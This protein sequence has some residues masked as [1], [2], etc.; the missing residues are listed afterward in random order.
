MKK[1]Y[2]LCIALSMLFLFHNVQAQAPDC[3]TNISPANLSTNINPYPFITFKWNA[4]SGASSYDIYVNTKVPPKQLVGT[5][6]VDSFNFNNA[7]YNT[8]Y[9][10]YVVPKNA[11]G[12]AIGCVSSAT[13]FT[14]SPPPPPPA[15]DNCGGAANISYIPLNGTTLGATQSQPANACGG[16]TGTAN[17]DVWYQFTPLTSGPITV[18]AEGSSSFDGVLEAFSGACGSLTSLSCSDTS[19]AGGREQITLNVEA[20]VNYKFR[21]YNFYAELSSRGTFSISIIPTPLPVTLL[22]FKG[23]RRANKNVLSWSTATELNNEGFELQYSADGTN[24]GKVAFVNSKAVNGNSSTILSYEFADAGQ[25][26][27]N[28][29][30]RLKQVDKKGQSNFSNIIFLKGEKVN[31]IT[32]GKI[33]PNP[34]KNKLNVA[35]AAPES[36]KIHLIVTDVAGKTVKQQSFAIING[37]NKLTVDV[38]GLPGGNYFIKAISR[39]GSQTDASKFVKE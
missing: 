1:I 27:G 3:T 17:D 30:Y 29:Y 6:S 2:T 5:V 25:L 10:W 28:A 36:S 18:N 32:L 21:I 33:Y 35:I 14:T 34:A 7:S 37:D 8:A 19:Q 15:N 23:E 4:V 39:D 22:N 20:G 26:S 9:Y 31:T 16:Y 38:A 24:F 12:T 11:D 13:T